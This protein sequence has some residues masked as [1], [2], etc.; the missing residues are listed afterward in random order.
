[1]PSRSQFLFRQCI[2][3]KPAKYTIYVVW[4]CDARTLY[5]L[6]RDVC[7]F[8]QC[9]LLYLSLPKSAKTHLSCIN[10]DVHLS[11]F[12]LPAVPF[13]ERNDQ[14][15]RQYAKQEQK[16]HLHEG[17]MHQILFLITFPVNSYIMFYILTSD[18]H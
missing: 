13:G 5:P 8:S 17:V 14:G 4:Y 12:A 3:K 18:T 7:L 10:F 16:N 1:M 15:L 2:Y 9:P 11:L 6:N